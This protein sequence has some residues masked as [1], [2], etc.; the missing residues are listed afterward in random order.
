MRFLKPLD[1]NL[2]H[3]ICS[4]HKAIITVEDGSLNGGL[5]SAIAEFIVLHGYSISMKSHG[6]KDEFIS[7]GKPQELYALC[8]LTPEA[9]AQSIQ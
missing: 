8:G 3:D 5:S 7:H 2:L 6:I 1:Q 9:I 4:T